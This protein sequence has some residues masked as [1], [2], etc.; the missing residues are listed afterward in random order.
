MVI[1][2]PR[3][4]AQGGGGGFLVGGRGHGS[5]PVCM[6]KESRRS[7]NLPDRDPA[8]GTGSKGLRAVVVAGLRILTAGCVKISS[9]Q[10]GFDYPC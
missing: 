10:R 2:V 4:K 5:A 7:I 9:T 6:F 1:A 8:P 3:A